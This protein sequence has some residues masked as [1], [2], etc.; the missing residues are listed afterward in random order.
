VDNAPKT[1]EELQPREV[2]EQSGNVDIL[3]KEI[4]EKDNII[5]V[6]RQKLECEAQDSKVLE[7][8]LQSVVKSLEDLKGAAGRGMLGNPDVLIDKLNTV[9]EKAM[10]YTGPPVW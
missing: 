9:Q 4:L 2:S 8:A 6:L 10:S 5:S 3:R 1:K 7:Q